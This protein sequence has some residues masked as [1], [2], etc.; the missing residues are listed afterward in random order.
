[1]VGSGAASTTETNTENKSF[2]V[3]DGV[4]QTP[5]SHAATSQ[6]VSLK[7][8]LT[9]ETIAVGGTTFNLMGS[10]TLRYVW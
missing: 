6:K 1:M 4:E 9:G 7:Q 5:S 10:F 3:Q 2:A 8:G